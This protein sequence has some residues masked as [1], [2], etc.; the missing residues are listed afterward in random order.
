MYKGVPKYICINRH[1]SKFQDAGQLIRRLF[2]IATHLF[3]IFKSLSRQRVQTSLLTPR[4][5]GRFEE[6]KS[7][8]QQKLHTDDVDQ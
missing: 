4:R 8:P 3:I 6:E 5:S 2:L 1:L 7:A